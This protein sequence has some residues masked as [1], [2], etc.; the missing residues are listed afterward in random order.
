MSKK[1]I[2]IVIGGYLPAKGYGGWTTSTVNFVENL[3]DLHNIYIVCNDCE[4]KTGKKLEGIK[5]GWNDV[6]K[7]KVMYIN[8]SCYNIKFYKKIIDEVNID[9]VYMSSLFYFKMN[10]PAIIASKK[11][12]VPIILL[13]RGELN[14]KALTIK[15]F[16]KKVY[17]F[18]L[19]LFGILKGIHFQATSSEEYNAIKKY[20]GIKEDKIY[21]L[22][23]LPKGFKLYENK[24][25]STN[26]FVYVSR[27][28]E[29]KNLLFV[30]ECLKE[31]KSEVVFDIY[32]P[33]EQQWYWEK[34]KN[35]ITE[36]P[37]NVKVEYK[38]VA[39]LEDVGEIF[40]NHYCFLC[41]TFGENYG[42]AIHEALLSNCHIILSKDTTPWNNLNDNG[43][44]VIPLNDKEK[45]IE[46]IEFIASL[47]KKGKQ[48]LDA[49]LNTYL[50]NTLCDNKI[51]DKYFKII[52]EVTKE[53]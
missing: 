14:K 48:D 8:P 21:L 19:K 24:S 43:C 4:Y 18:A 53:S 20:L 46:K 35:A 12:K 11:K 10:F 44:F 9:L 41:S 25:E 37:K 30:L 29:I 40:A 1:N 23:N 42:Q 36:L 28:H 15:G 50:L 27:I 26:K 33:L 16:K 7:A 3:G 51:V 6:G 39:K 31:V 52:D 2:L 5:E 38:G 45:W 17:I 49:Q 13:V 22:A 32:G 47:N 34:C